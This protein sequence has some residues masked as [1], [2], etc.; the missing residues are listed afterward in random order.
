MYMYLVV[1]YFCRSYTWT[2]E[3]NQPELCKT[4]L[5]YKNLFSLTSK[6]LASYMGVFTVFA[7]SQ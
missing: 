7:L 3:P 2:T 5:T 1:Q 4:T 6:I